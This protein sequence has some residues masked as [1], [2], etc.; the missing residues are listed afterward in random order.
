MYFKTFVIT[1]SVNHLCQFLIGNVFLDNANAKSRGL[2]MC[3]FLIGNVFQLISSVSNNDITLF[4]VQNQSKIHKKA[5]DLKQ[6]ISCQG[7]ILLHSAI[8]FILSRT[9]TGFFA[10]NCSI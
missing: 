5:V 10:E 9:S 4:S 6:L 2:E 3:Q 7:L 8:F 1:G